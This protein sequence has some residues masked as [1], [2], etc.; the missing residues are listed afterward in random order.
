MGVAGLGHFTLSVNKFLIRAR[1]LLDLRNG[2]E[3]G[4]FP[5][6]ESLTITL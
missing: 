3:G 2:E 5:Y 4:G 6:T 1:N